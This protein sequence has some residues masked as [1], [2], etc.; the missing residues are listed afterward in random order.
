MQE[1]EQAKALP[2]VMRRWLFRGEDWNDDDFYIDENG[3]EVCE[4]AAVPWVG[5]ELDAKAEAD[6]RCDLW[7]ES[8]EAFIAKITIE[9]RGKAT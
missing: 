1:N 3:A 5:S 4:D 7:E 8:N 9:S 6:R 2:V